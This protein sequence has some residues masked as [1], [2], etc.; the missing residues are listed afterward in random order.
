MKAVLVLNGEPPEM[1]RLREW[2]ADMPVYAAD[3]GAR[4]CLEA[5]VR[6][7]WVVGDFDSVLAE[8]LPD[9][10]ELRHLEDQDSTDFEKLLRCLPDGLDD[11][12]VLGAFGKRLDHMLT[13]LLI[14]SAL[15][16]GFGIRF[17]HRAEEL[18]RVTPERPWSGS[19]R[20]GSTL[21]LLPMSKVRGVTTEGL[22]WNLNRDDMNAELKL[23]QSN[24]VTGP[25]SVRVEDGSLFLWR[26]ISKE[27]R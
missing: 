26:S 3:G 2:A 11:V 13:N 12:V 22:F 19:P 10:W 27:N 21:S 16:P 8:D 15:P 18:W 1:D 23:G 24:R 14:A 20:E 4:I 5:G 7:E 6:P 9:D 17:E 25:V